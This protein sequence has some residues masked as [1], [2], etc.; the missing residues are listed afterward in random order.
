MK[1]YK[2]AG[3]ALLCLGSV[4]SC[5]T[6]SMFDA[7]GDE[8][9]IAVPGGEG[10]NTSAG[11][12]TAGEWND[13]DHWDFWGK[14]FKDE[15]ITKASKVWE[16]NVDKRIA[17][18]VTD[19]AGKAV[20]GARV[21]ATMD[22]KIVWSTVTDNHGTANL[23]LNLFDG[24]E[25][26]DDAVLKVR[27]NGK[28]QSGTPVISY[29]QDGDAKVNSYKASQKAD[30][31]NSVDVAFV[32]DA[33]G[34]MEDEIRFL[35]DDI[36]DIIGKASAINSASIRTGAIFYRDEEDEYVTRSS[37]LTAK[38][39]DTREFIRHQSA[40][41]GGDYPEAVHTALE[42][43]LQELDWN[44]YA[45]SRIAFLIL[46][47]PAHLKTKVVE[48]LHKSIE[49]FADMGII[50]I[51][52]AASG[53]DLQTEFML[54]NFAIVTNGTYTFLTNDSGVGGDHLEPRVGE[55]EVEKLNELM[56]RLISHYME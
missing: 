32:V 17:V 18:K 9:A 1:L 29:P 8:S 30:I 23:W 4:A 6:E 2:I 14:L 25:L 5:T 36:E 54:R 34:S 22:S 35:Q 7:V 43:T 39:A 53:A 55:F 37:Q 49:K 11:V 38:T 19:A 33:T 24:K 26:D 15:D 13:L 3:V 20:S 46:D 48:S 51:P 31:E 12:L 28:E 44:V 27:I 41:G 50:I 42:A 56:T 40:Y 45:K 47:A 52:V 16:F 10:G 21:E